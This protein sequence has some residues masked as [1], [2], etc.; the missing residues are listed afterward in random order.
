M[1]EIIIAAAVLLGV[2]CLVVKNYKPQT[3]IFL[4]GMILLAC[5]VIMGKPIIAVKQSTGNVWF[6]IFKVIE[7]LFSNRVAGLGLMIMSVAGFVRYMDHIGASKA[8]VKISVKPLHYVRSPYLVLAFGYILGQLMKM[9]ITSA[10]GLGMLLMATMF[11]V[12]IGIGASRTAAAAIIVTCSCID[13]GPAAA[14]SNLIAKTAGID[15]VAYF[16]NYQIMIAI[17]V[18]LVIA[19]LHYCVQSWFDKKDNHVAV[20]SEFAVAVTDEAKSPVIYGILPIIPLL[21]IFIFSPIVGSSIKMSLVSAMLF[22]IF[23]SMICEYIRYRDAQKVFKSIQSFFDGMGNAFATIVTLVVAG[24][25]FANGLTAIGAVDMVLN[26][27]KSAGF[28]ADA[29]TIL[30]QV[31]I[32]GATIVTGSGDAS[33]FSFVGLVPTIA[34]Q[35]QIDPVYLLLPMQFAATIARAVS[36]IS[37][38]CIAVAGI[39][40]VSPV[41]VVKRTAIPMAGAMI[42]TTIATI[43]VF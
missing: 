31:V 28:G 42:V 15:S 40:S 23:I 39:A 13:L 36:P 29:M 30:L 18:M 24:E 21:I 4:G 8:F 38:V 22:G 11:P 37:A 16:V 14:T 26:A 20:S 43:I 7:N 34:S 6:D 5:A 35:Y 1:L 41:E 19:A 27:S 10:A 33:M 12:L 25:T 32:A 17:P 2:S 3:V 9:A